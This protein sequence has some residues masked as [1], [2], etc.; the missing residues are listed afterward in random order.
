[1]QHKTLIS[2]KTLRMVPS[3]DLIAIFA[4]RAIQNTQISQHQLTA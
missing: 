4:A 2:W 1:M 3:L